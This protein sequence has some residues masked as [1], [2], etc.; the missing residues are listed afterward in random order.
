MSIIV[1][2]LQQS[3]WIQYQTKM[4]DPKNEFF[5]CIMKLC[6]NCKHE[7][8]GLLFGVF[9][10]V[11]GCVFST[12]LAF[13]YYQFK[14]LNL[15]VSSDVVKEHM[16]EDF[17]QKFPRMRTIFDASE[18]KIQK[19]SNASDQ[20]STW[21]SYKNLNTLKIMVGVS[22]RGLLTY[23]SPA[24]GSSAS[25]CQIIESSELLDGHFI[26]GSC[27]WCYQARLRNSCPGSLCNTGHCS[28]HTNHIE[29]YLPTTSQ[30]C[31]K[32][33]LNC[34]KKSPHWEGDWPC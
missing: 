24:F 18:I 3:I 15:V 27:P 9:S 7:D 16:L 11:V 2:D 20:W 4:R 33:Q 14:E 32:R 8:L 28:Q 19:P 10:K 17:G 34:F 31:C 26:P 30:N 12:W 6:L 5:L 29:R 1:L 13:M 25:D 21:S 23:V 22:P